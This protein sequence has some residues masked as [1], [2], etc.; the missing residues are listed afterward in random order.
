MGAEG[1]N[2]FAE[3]I[4]KLISEGWQPTGG[5]SAIIT[6][7]QK[8]NNPE[9]LAKGLDMESKILTFQAMVR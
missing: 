7:G 1:G 2:K 8:T 3:E 6:H 5:V 9:F 4:T